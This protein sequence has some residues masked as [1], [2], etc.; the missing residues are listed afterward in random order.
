MPPVVEPDGNELPRAGDRAPRRLPCAT[1][2]NRCRSTAASA[3]SLPGAIHSGVK[4]GTRSDRS[5]AWPWESMAPGF[6]QPLAPWRI[7]FMVCL[8]E[9]EV[10]SGKWKVGRKWIGTRTRALHAG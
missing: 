2:G 10:G 6:S 9:R 8:L 3:A 4:S 1:S 5:R 7:S